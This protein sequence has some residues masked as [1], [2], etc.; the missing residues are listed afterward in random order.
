MSKSVMQQVID[1]FSESPLSRWRIDHKRLWLEYLKT[2]NDVE[3]Y[4]ILDNLEI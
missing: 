1:H 3:N 2:G 4:D